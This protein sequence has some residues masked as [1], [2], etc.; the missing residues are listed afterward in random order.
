[1]SGKEKEGWCSGNLEVTKRPDSHRSTSHLHRKHSRRAQHQQ[2]V[3]RQAH[4]TD[5]TSFFNLL[6]G[7]ELL[8][9][10]EDNL[11]AH[12]ERLYHPTQ[13]LTM[14][15]SQA[16]SAD[17]SCQNAVTE[18]AIHRLLDGLKPCSI[19]TGGYCRARQ[20]LP[21]ELVSTLVRT[22]GAMMTKH[23]LSA[24]KIQGRAVKLIDGTTVTMP[25]TPVNQQRYPQQRSQKPGAGFPLA[26]AVAIICLSSGAIINAA[27]GP[28]KGEHG[29]E[30]ALLRPL[31][32]SFQS[33]DVVLADRYYASYF[34][35]AALQARGVSF[36]MQ[37]HSA[38]KTD[39]RKGRRLGARDHIVQWR[40]PQ[41]P[42]WM[43][44]GEYAA[45]PATLEIR[46]V[47]VKRKTLI[48][49]LSERDASKH[50]MADLYQ[51]RW[52][53][54]LDFRGIKAIWGMQRLSCKTAGNAGNAE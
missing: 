2:V 21:T 50:D 29:S 24:W 35:L 28:Y 17:A 51:Q 45:M 47:R 46:E 32:D 13:T 37:Q 49:S 41:R 7:P 33:G 19:K 48:T 12:R 14:F 4:Q 40:R 25:D 22:T 44:T 27:M 31:L 18:V 38:R 9:V 39:F 34:L 42:Y 36:V 15:L 8:S 54:E 20:R 23:S 5:S 1:L 43:S 10:I 52:L 3:A 30:H 6:T 11:L 26:R 53:V 16:L